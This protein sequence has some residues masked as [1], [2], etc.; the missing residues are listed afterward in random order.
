MSETHK[1]DRW[2]A[3]P[4]MTPEEFAEW[5]RKWHE[6]E[7]KEQYGLQCVTSRVLGQIQDETLVK[8]KLGTD[9]DKWFLGQ[10]KISAEGL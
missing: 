10:L 2:N 8:M 9:F 7:L 6:R 5:Q 4:R 3:R 1:Y